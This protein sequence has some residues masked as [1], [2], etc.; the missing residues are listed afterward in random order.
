MQHIITWSF[1]N[2]HSN[3]ECE[4]ANERQVYL[5]FL[6]EYYLKVG[7]RAEEFISILLSAK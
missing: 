2:T 5:I 7:N 3:I 6:N 1:I 4:A